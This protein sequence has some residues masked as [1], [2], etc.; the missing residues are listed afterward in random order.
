MN[1]IDLLEGS[2]IGV[3]CIVASFCMK[4]KQFDL[5]NWIKY[6][7]MLR[8]QFTIMTHCECEMLVLNT[9]DLKVMKNEFY[10]VYI[11]FFERSLTILKRIMSQKLKAIK[12]STSLISDGKD[13]FSDE[14]ASFKV[15]NLS[16]LEEQ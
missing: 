3:S 2:E 5:E 14:F 13:E 12:Y 8:H 6:R 4:G 1:Y 9:Q 10:E 11:Q 16:E 7:D 15:F